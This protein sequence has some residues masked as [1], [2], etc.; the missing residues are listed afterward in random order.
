MS[1]TRLIQRLMVAVTAFL[2]ALLTH[3]FGTTR[4]ARRKPLYPIASALVCLAISNVA[5]GGSGC[6]GSPSQRDS[7]SSRVPAGL[8]QCLR[9]LTHWLL[10]LTS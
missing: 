8:T 3:R 4:S 2:A 6:D 9:Y 10:A 7:F 1:A 5:T